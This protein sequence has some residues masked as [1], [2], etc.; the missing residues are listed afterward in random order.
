MA[1]LRNEQFSSRL[2]EIVSGN[3]AGL[4]VLP[5]ECRPP[6]AVE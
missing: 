6:D 5:A 3:V 2:G 1:D 4:V